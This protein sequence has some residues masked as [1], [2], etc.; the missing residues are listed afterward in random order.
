MFEPILTNSISKI[1]KES[2]IVRLDT[3]SN[4]DGTIHK[5][6]L[7]LYNNN[8]VLILAENNKNLVMIKQF[9][10]EWGKYTWELPGGGIEVGEDLIDT[11]VRELLEET[12]YELLTPQ[13]IQ[14]CH[15][16][17]HLAGKVN[18]IHG[19]FIGFGKIKEPLVDTISLFN[20]EQIFELIN[21]KDIVSV[22]TLAGLSLAMFKNII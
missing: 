6:R 4:S 5:E 20:R 18:I 10:P 22:Q 3:Y 11:A 9:R 16:S 21:Q 17:V 13:L 12:G 1:E 8:G 14:E 19:R 2:I 7:R 15:V